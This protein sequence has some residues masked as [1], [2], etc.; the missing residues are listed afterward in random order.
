VVATI[1][2]LW[3]PIL[4]SAVGVFV[5]S[6]VMH[7]VLT[8]HRKDFSQVP[9][10]D[11]VAD[12][13]RGAPAGQYMFPYSA[14]MKEMGTP[15]MVE[16]F[17]RGPVGILTLR[18]TGMPSMGPFLVQW[19]IFSVVVGI[20]VAYVCSRTLMAGVDYLGVFRVAGVIAFLGYA[21]PEATRSIWG[22]QPW[23]ATVRNYVDGVI[24]ALVT[25]GVF[26]WLW[27]WRT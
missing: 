3:L 5:V 25:A 9:N 11:R 18:R 26:A 17:K 22:G 13:L 16:K 8:Y 2:A 12:A 23:G 14:S 15:A 24:Y 19:F 4:L 1:T 10:E 21:G 27:P 6:S 20:F 7:M